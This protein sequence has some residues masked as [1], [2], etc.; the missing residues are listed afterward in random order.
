MPAVLRT[1]ASHLRANRLR[2]LDAGG[3]RQGVRM[4]ATLRRRRKSLLALLPDTSPPRDSAPGAAIR[5][6]HVRPATKVRRAAH[7]QAID[8]NPPRCS[9]QN[10][11]ADACRRSWRDDDTVA[12]GKFSRADFA[13]DNRSAS[14][15]K[16]PSQNA[17]A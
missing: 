12:R 17:A 6:P 7:P 13:D 3:N 1:F 15:E 16:C 14:C 9:P 4:A 8:A 5:R 2:L 11:L 10:F